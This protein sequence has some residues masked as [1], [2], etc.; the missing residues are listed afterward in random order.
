MDLLPLGFGSDVSNQN[1]AE[2]IAALLGVRGLRRL[3][4][5]GPCPVL[6]RGDSKTALS[7]VSKMKFRS[8][9]VGNAASFFVLQ[10][11]I[12]EVEVVGEEHLI[13]EANWRTDGLS[14]G[15]SLK[16]LAKRDLSLANI[17]FIDLDA[18]GVLE[19]CDPRLSIRSDHDFALFWRRT[20][21]VINSNV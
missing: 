19:L 12:L 15:K 4:V 2:F 10:N 14:R 11:I 9:L 13:A 20:K 17:P 7:W 21:E 16:D 8:D 18:A 6:F 1:I 3:G 5:V